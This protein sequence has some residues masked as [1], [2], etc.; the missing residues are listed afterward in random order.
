MER[1]MAVFGAPMEIGGERSEWGEVLTPVR[2]KIPP[3]RRIDRG[4]G[5]RICH[6]LCH[7]RDSQT[8]GKAVDQPHSQHDSFPFRDSPVLSTDGLQPRE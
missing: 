4:G 1:Q 8:C 2:M 5:R 3:G 6:Q 7:S